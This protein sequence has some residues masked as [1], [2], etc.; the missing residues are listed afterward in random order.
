MLGF[1]HIAFTNFLSNKR[2]DGLLES[3]CNH[4]A[5]LQ[6][7]H[8]DCLGCLSGH[9]KIPTHELHQLVG[10]PLQAHHQSTWQSNSYLI[11]Y[12]P[13]QAPKTTF[14]I[15]FLLLQILLRLNLT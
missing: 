3:N 10:P 14:G 2:T 11:F 1:C 5:Q 7:G 4:E 9:S 13:R 12:P 15:Q 8:Q 6:N